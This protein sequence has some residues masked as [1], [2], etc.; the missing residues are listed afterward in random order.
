MKRKTLLNLRLGDCHVA[1][2]FAALS[3]QWVSMLLVALP[4]LLTACDFSLAGDITPPPDA[5]ISSTVPCAFVPRA[6]AMTSAPRL[7]S[8]CAIARP[9]PRDA[10][11]T[12]TTRSLNWLMGRFRTARSGGQRRAQPCPRDAQGRRCGRTWHPARPSAPIPR[13]RSPGRPRRQPLLPRPR[14]VA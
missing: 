9:I 12:T 13:A 10:P 11:V 7:A 14:A 3:S 2:S 8:S 1:R 4:L 6:A 5:M